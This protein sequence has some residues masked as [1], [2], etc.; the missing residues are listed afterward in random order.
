MNKTLFFA[1]TAIAFLILPSSKLLAQ[2]IVIDYSYSFPV[3]EPYYTCDGTEIFIQ[4]TIA[5]FGKGAINGKRVNFNQHVN[6]DLTGVDAAGN[7]YIGKYNQNVTRNGTYEDGA[8][9]ASTINILDS[10][11]FVSQ[12]SGPNFTE[13]FQAHLTVTPNGQVT[14]DRE[15]L[16]PDCN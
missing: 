7:T 11:R 14:V 4:G 1:V 15:R 16:T 2:T 13:R 12:G 10:I 8:Y 5:V 3:S 9:T 6:A